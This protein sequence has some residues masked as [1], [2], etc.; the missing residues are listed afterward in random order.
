MSERAVLLKKAPQIEQHTSPQ[1]QP[2]A[3]SHE[4][5]SSTER[6]TFNTPHFGPD[7]SR[8]RVQPPSTATLQPKLMV[9]T[10]G[11]QFE[12]EAEQMAEE[13]MGMEAPNAR[14]ATSAPSEKY[15]H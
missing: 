8:I 6:L 2:K 7:F 3:L 11:D 10:P 4:N 9:N 1:S 15:I 5:Q 13:V 12:Q 14:S